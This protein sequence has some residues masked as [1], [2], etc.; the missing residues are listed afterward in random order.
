[1]NE[2]FIIL[3][4]ARSGKSLVAG[5][6]NCVPDIQIHNGHEPLNG[7]H[8]MTLDYLD[9][10]KQEL[11]LLDTLNTLGDVKVI[12]T[13][14][15]PIQSVCSYIQ[16]LGMSARNAL[17]YWFD[18]NTIL[19]YFCTSLS[20]R[21]FILMKYEDV[22]L[23]CQ[24]MEHIFEFMNLTHSDQ[25]RSYGDFDHP[26]LSCPIFNQGKP[27]IERIAPYRISDFCLE[28][29]C[30]IYRNKPLLG[31]LRYELNISD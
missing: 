4:A 31:F 12:W 22:L 9:Y 18:I 16:N 6:V 21:N 20:E 3:G 26:A 2:T 24:N 19:W 1:M 25:Y 28:D 15:N 13:V 27:D 8:V 7:I 10:V 14:R 30:K 29:Q 5:M 11:K 17:K 23:G